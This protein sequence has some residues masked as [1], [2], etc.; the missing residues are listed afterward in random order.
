MENLT[1]KD[2]KRIREQA[3][4]IDAT[5]KTPMAQQMMAYWKTNRPQMTH[6]L[7]RL[8]ILHQ[9]AVVQEENYDKE[10]V[11]LIQE[12]EMPQSEAAM[13]AGQHL[14]MT[15]ENEEQDETAPPNQPDQTT[16]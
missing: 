1:L 5:H 16:T 9:F 8:G 12:Q 15:P 11:R 4:Q 2:A 6:R 13:M 7:M 14:L 3:S 10:M